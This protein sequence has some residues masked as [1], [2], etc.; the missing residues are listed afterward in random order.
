MKRLKKGFT[1]RDFLKT[2]AFT[3]GA[4]AAGTTLLSGSNPE[5]AEAVHSLQLGS[6]NH[7][8][9]LKVFDF[10]GKLGSELRSVKTGDDRSATSAFLQALP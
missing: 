7:C 3:T 4:T 2:S 10:T 8:L 1:R 6:L 9:R 5:L